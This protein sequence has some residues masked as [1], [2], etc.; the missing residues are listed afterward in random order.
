MAIVRRAAGKGHWYQVD[1]VKYDGVTTLLKDGIPK[2]ALINWA[3]RSVAEHVA[4]NIEAVIGMREMGR[5]SIV[6]ALKD[7]HYSRRNDAA[8]KGTDIH[9]IAEK[10]TLGEEVEVPEHLVGHVEACIKFLHDWQIEPL[11][12]ECPVANR[13]WR[14]AGTPDLIAQADSPTDGPVVG[15][16]DWKTGA[17]GVFPE[18]AYQIAAYRYAEAY[19]DKDG[20]ERRIADLGITAGYAVWLR[21]DGYDVYPLDCGEQTFKVFTHVA[22]VA[23]HTKD[24]RHLIGEAIYA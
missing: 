21:A 5:D 15:V 11:A 2:P 1:G 7:V 9:A 18:A 6:G 17:S 24:D 3:A 22:F 14:Y 13:K 16:F 8:L 10:I 12:T 19:V 20:T 23:R 4:D